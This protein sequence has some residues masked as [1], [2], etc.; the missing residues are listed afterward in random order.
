MSSFEEDHIRQLANKLKAIGYSAEDVMLL[1]Q[2]PHLGLVREVVNGRAQIV[3][4]KTA[5]DLVVIKYVV[6]VAGNIS[7]QV[8]AGCYSWFNQS[9]SDCS[10]TADQPHQ[11]EVILKY[12][13]RSM[14]AH[15]VLRRLDEEG[16]RFATMSELL[17]FGIRYPDLQLQHPIVVF[18]YF[19]RS[20]RSG[21]LYAGCL[22][23]REEERILDFKEAEGIWSDSCRFLV[24]EK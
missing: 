13:A 12:F 11:A 15:E 3:V 14:S 23:R 22:E 1:A 4:K 18:T 19:R 16:L 20:L 21:G 17:A 5:A 7:D 24:V 9:I 8:K 6:E 2:F 10:Y